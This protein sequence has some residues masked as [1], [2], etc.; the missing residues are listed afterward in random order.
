M[1][2]IISA[3][4]SDG[5]IGKDNDLII[6]SPADMRHFKEITEGDVVVMGFNTWKSLKCKPLPNRFNIVIVGN[7]MMCSENTLITLRDDN[8]K[9]CFFRDLEEVVIMVMRFQLDHSKVF[10][11]GGAKI[12]K[13]ALDKN[14]VNRM[15]LTRF[16]EPNIKA[17]VLFPE[18]NWKHFKRKYI[19]YKIHNGEKIEIHDYNIADERATEMTYN[20]LTGILDR[21]RCDRRVLENYTGGLTYSDNKDIMD[22]ELNGRNT[23]IK[24][25]YIQ[26]N[27]E[28]NF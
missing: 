23:H 17:D 28:Y 10:I 6:K 16:N 3:I 11:I 12:Y 4:N 20:T 21:W 22:I 15:V 19:N 27:S 26:Y 9:I 5:G 18:V 8:R 7:D 1:F 2:T 14:L 13:D 25:P 24:Q